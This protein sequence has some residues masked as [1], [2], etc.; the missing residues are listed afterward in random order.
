MAFHAKSASL[1]LITALCFLCVMQLQSSDCS[2]GSGCLY[3]KAAVHEV[4]NRK[5]LGGVKGNEVVF[6]N[7]DVAGSAMK[8]DEGWDLREAPLGPD[9]LHH[10]GGSPKKP[11]TP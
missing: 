10:H 8:I 11:K 1:L 3:V 5:L 6:K 7:N 4:L 2:M 9:P